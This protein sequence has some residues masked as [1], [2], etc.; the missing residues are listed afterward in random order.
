MVASI[1][2]AN[3]VCGIFDEISIS[4]VQFRASGSLA[5]ESM[6]VSRILHELIAGERRKRAI[7]GRM[8]EMIHYVNRYPDCTI[9]RMVLAGT[10]NESTGAT[11]PGNSHFLVNA[12]GKRPRH[13]KP[14]TV[15]S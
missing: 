11:A 10:L 4:I 14:I 7:T 9:L 13:R 3:L 12:C 15:T 6:Q 5:I 1:R 8:C 2:Y